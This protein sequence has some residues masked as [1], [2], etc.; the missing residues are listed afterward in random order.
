MKRCRKIVGALGC[1]SSNAANVYSPHYNPGAGTSS[2]GAGTSSQG[3]GTSSHAAATSSHAAA[4]SS[5]ACGYEITNDDADS[6]ADY[7]DDADGDYVDEINVSQMEDA[8]AVTQ[9]SQRTNRGPHPNPFSPDLFQR[10]RRTRGAR[11]E[12]RSKKNEDRAGKRGR[13]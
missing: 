6:E 2:Q 9:P 11:K 12:V 5:H 7:E 8:P 3:A 13:R 1:S 4:T 10:D